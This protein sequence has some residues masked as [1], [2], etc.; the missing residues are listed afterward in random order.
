MAGIGRLNQPITSAALIQLE[1]KFITG[2]PGGE[3]RNARFIWRDYRCISFAGRYSKAMCTSSDKP[4]YVWLSTSPS[5]SKAS[6]P[7]FYA[8]SPR[9]GVLVTPEG[10]PHAAHLD[11]PAASQPGAT[12]FSF[13]AF[14]RAPAFLEMP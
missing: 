5:R 14:H 2:A 1:F 9:V 4:S 8:R 11:A 3:V 12:R 13:F 6:L 7:A 10:A